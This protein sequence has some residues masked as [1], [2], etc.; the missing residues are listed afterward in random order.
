MKNFFYGI[1]KWQGIMII[2]TLVLFS[3]GLLGYFFLG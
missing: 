3:I 1:P 2:V